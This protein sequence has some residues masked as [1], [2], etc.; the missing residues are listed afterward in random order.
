MINGPQ[1]IRVLAFVLLVVRL[2]DP[3]E[4][5]HEHV[6]ESGRDVTHEGH[7]EEG[8][9]QDGMLDEVYAFDHVGVPSD[10]REVHEE[11]KELDQDAD[12]GGLRYV[13]GAMEMNA[14]GSFQRHTGMATSNLMTMPASTANA[15][16]L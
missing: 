8:Y 10:L 7:Q 9:L 13:L 4:R 12:A 1:L 16:C 3:C 6:V 15:A 11:A 14:E 5:V 2:V